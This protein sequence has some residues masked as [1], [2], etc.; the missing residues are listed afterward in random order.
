MFSVPTVYFNWG[1][2]GGS[3]TEGTLENDNY[4]P[5]RFFSSL[6]NDTMR[7]FGKTLFSLEGFE[8]LSVPENGDL[9]FQ[10]SIWRR[11]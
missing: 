4:E 5:K 7:L 9:Q 1:Q 8:M 10:S 3:N 2:Y 11:S 6:S